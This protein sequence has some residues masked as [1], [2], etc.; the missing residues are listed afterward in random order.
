[1]HDLELRQLSGQL[2][3]EKNR[4]NA[5]LSI[6]LYMLH[7]MKHATPVNEMPGGLAIPWEDFVGIPKKWMMKA[8]PALVSDEDAGEDDEP[9]K[10]MVVQILPLPDNGQLVVPRPGVRL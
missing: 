1:M 6:C 7:S 5:Y 9:E 4:A 10:M 3:A 2:A 8:E